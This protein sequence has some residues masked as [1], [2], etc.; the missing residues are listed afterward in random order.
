M[1]A[2]A[3]QLGLD[4]GEW[5]DLFDE[6]HFYDPVAPQDDAGVREPQR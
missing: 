6:R 5:P 1:L 4:Q 3:R 2:R